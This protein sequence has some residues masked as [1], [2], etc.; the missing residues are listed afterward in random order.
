MAAGRVDIIPDYPSISQLPIG[1][2][3]KRLLDSVPC[4]QF[5]DHREAFVG[6]ASD[7]CAQKK[8]GGAIEG[9]YWHLRLPQLG[10]ILNCAGILSPRPAFR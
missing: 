7:R 5:F 2:A 8:R 3:A 9:L 10:V 1:D 6:E 4:P